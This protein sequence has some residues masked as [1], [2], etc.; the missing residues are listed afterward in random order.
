M[1]KLTLSL[2]A[3]TLLAGCGLYS[4]TQY[5]LQLQAQNA[6]FSHKEDLKKGST[7]TFL[8]LG[9]IPWPWHKHRTPDTLIDAIKQEDIQQVVW[10]DKTY[11]YKFTYANSCRNVYGY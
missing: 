3:V 6:D 1:K 7:C 8:L 9:V 4:T 2:L 10:I 5:N 11:D